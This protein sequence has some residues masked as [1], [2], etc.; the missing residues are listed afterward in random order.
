MIRRPPRSTLFPYTT[1]FRSVVQRDQDQRAEQRHHQQQVHRG[2]GTEPA[3]PQQR[4]VDQRLP[5][6]GQSVPEEQRDQRQPGQH[7]DARPPAAEAAAR[8]HLGPAAEQ[9]GDSGGEQAGGRPPAEPERPSATQEPTPPRRARTPP[10]TAAA[11][12]PTRV[13]RRTAR[14]PTR[15]AG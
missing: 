5:A 7:R 6:T 4:D 15:S 3:P 10:G 2:R 8:T 12:R 11:R 13:W 9:Y 14:P 1:L